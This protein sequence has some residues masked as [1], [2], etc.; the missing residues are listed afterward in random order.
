M[1]IWNLVVQRLCATAL[2][3]A[4]L[5]G[6]ATV[7]AQREPYTT[8]RDKTAKGAG[9][10]AAAGAVGAVIAGKREADE[11]LAGAAIGAVV[12]GG[13]GAYMDAQ[14]EKLARIPGTTVE[15]VGD[16][17][18]LVHFDSDVLFAVDSAS[19]TAPSRQTLEEVA[20]VLAEYPKT[21]VVVQGHT[22]S[23]GSEEHN[24]SLSERRAA[25]VRG[26]LVG[27]GVDAGRLAAVGYGEDMPVA[28]NASAAG[29]QQNRRVDVLLKARAV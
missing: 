12:G 6:C 23:T 5:A 24:Q 22:D 1:S 8:R 17:T 19:L 2:V 15:R 27:R 7:A 11:I 18:L 20:A 25:A 16:D 29:R 10:G 3:A 14:E 9:A 4:A 21:A 26:Y 13:V 28:S